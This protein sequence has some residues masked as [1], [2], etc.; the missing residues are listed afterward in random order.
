MAAVDLGR[1]PADGSFDHPISKRRY[2][3]VRKDG[4]LLHRELLRTD[5]PGEVVLSEY[6]VKYVVGSGRHS[7]TY[8][9]E[10]EGFL[11][12]SPVTWYASKKAWGMSPG[13]DR[14][15]HSGFERAV[16]ASCLVCH[17]GRADPVGGS[18]HRMDIKE[19]AISCERCHGPGALHV[20]RHSGSGRTDSA[21]DRF[22]ETIVNP[23]HLSRDLAEAVCQQCHLRSSASVL[24]CGRKLDDF[25]PGLPLEDFLHEFRLDTPNEEMAVV[26]H[27]EQMHLSRCYQESETFSC[28]TCHNP[29]DEP[30]PHRREA[31]YK[32]TCLRCHQPEACKVDPAVRHVRS[33]SNNCV[34]CHM[35]TSATEIPH[36]AFTHHRVG[37]HEP[38]EGTG[39]PSARTSVL[40]DLEPVLDHS[41]V[42]AI[43]RRRSLG[44]A[45][46]KVADQSKDASLAERY[47]VRALKLLTKVR[48]EWLRD[49]VVDAALAYL[50][51]DLGLEGVVPLAEGALADGNLDAQDRCNVLFLIAESLARAGRH[52]EAIP[53]LREL[54]TLRRRSLQMLLLADCER[55]AGNPGFI[56]SLEG[57]V[58]INPRLWKVHKLL[59]DH[60]RRR[61]EEERAEYHQKR[62]VP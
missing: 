40:A 20:E 7:L 62:A 30:S 47:R 17:A 31:Y 3:V 34:R 33:P 21:A 45:Y 13:Y 53:K 4:Q 15:E 37:I 57:A 19:A 55:A 27:V 23:A 42:G 60:Y 46:R 6:P 52:A 24:P 49:G 26:G 12:E 51:F 54:T 39:S 22:D 44:L 9:V 14:K 36:L 43:D 11:V 32:D 41:R 2:Q 25:R 1:E 50:H 35:P 5:G 61:G 28:L 10:T 56:Q 48:S 16:G 58:R 29:H 18:L 38:R 8:L 59:A